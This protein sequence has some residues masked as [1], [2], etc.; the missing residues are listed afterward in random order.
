MPSSDLI[1]PMIGSAPPPPPTAACRWPISSLTARPTSRSVIMLTRPP[2]GQRSPSGWLPSTAPS[3]S[4]SSSMCRYPAS[5]PRSRST[6]R[7]QAPRIPAAGHRRLISATGATPGPPPSTST[8]CSAS[9]GG[10][11]APRRTSSRRRP[12]WQRTSFRISWVCGM[13]IRSGRQ[14]SASLPRRG[15]VATTTTQSMWARLLPGRPTV[16][17]SRHRP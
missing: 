14:D 15:G 1:C 17:S 13:P 9:R 5:T 3:A 16:T 11:R 6:S 10:R 12:G 7:G 8:A 4:S 2:S